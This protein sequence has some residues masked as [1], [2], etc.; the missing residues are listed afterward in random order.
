MNIRF[1]SLLDE[2]ITTKV[3]YAHN[4]MEEL[5]TPAFDETEQHGNQSVAVMET[6]ITVLATSHTMYK[7]GE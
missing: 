1:K 6:D 3:T 7:I 2:E 5:S 4:T